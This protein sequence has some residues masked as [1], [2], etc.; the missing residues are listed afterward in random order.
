MLEGM[1]KPMPW[2]KLM[3][4]VLMPMISPR[5]L[6]RGATGIAGIDRGVGLDEVFVARKIHIFPPD[7]ADHSQCDR[8]L[9][10]ERIPDGEHPL[11]DTNRA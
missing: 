6:K 2:A 5:R 4:A 9:Q 7:A 10:P 8:A 11:T 1:A 3:M